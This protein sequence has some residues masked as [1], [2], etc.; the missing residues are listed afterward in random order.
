MGL[1]AAAQPQ[2][3][4]AADYSLRLGFVLA[5]SDPLQIAAEGFKKAV[6]ERSKG[7]IEV[8]LYPSSATPRT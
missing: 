4:T 5:P 6:E 8:P 7:A 2:A 3:V 1:F